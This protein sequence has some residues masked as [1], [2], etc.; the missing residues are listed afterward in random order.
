MPS[1]MPKETQYW[2][3]PSSSVAS[4]LAKTLWPLQ[5]KNMFF[6]FLGT[7]GPRLPK[8]N[9]VFCGQSKQE[10]LVGMRPYADFSWQEMESSFGLCALL[11][12]PKFIKNISIARWCYLDDSRT[13]KQA[14][15][16]D[17]S[18]QAS[19]VH[20]M[21]FFVKFQW[22]CLKKGGRTVCS[23]MQKPHVINERWCILSC[24]LRWG[25]R[26]RDCFH[27]FYYYLQ[28]FS[29]TAFHMVTTT[30]KNEN[31]ATL[32]DMLNLWLPYAF[33]ARAGAA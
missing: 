7:E 4:I 16:S 27:V 10:T 14:D 20:L 28:K 11:S 13:I 17:K 31:W 26:A 1:W 22:C 6:V 5:D 24:W 3:R 25:K 12:F 32:I 9:F 21:G 33:S 2:P 8:N 29:Q 30:E 18:I 19:A 23:N 15:K